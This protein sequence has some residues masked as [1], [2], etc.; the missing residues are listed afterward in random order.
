[1]TDDPE[2]ADHVVDPGSPPQR[3]HDAERDPDH[4]LK[5]EGA[6]GELEGGRQALQ[7]ER[8]RGPVVLERLPEV[9]MDDLRDPVHVLEPDG[10]VESVVLAEGLDVLLGHVERPER[11]EAHGIAG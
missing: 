6:E 3:R 11:V 4:K 1:M 10:L 7:E 8:K 9:E 2:D 5:E